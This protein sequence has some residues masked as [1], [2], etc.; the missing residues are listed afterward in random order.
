MRIATTKNCSAAFMKTLTLVFVFV[1]ISLM[2]AGTLVKS[3]MANPWF[4]V[5]FGTFSPRTL[6]SVTSPANQS[7]FKVNI[8]SLTF[9]I[10]MSEWYQYDELPFISSKYLS[11][12][13]IEYYLDGELAG[14]IA[15]HL[16]KEAYSLSVPLNGVSNG[17]HSV[18]VKATTTGVNWQ[19]TQDSDGGISV[20]WYTSP[21]L[22]SSGVV[23][24]TVDGKSPTFTVQSPQ[25]KTYYEASIP[26]TFRISEQ[27]SRVAYSL[28]GSNEITIS[29]SALARIPHAPA[30]RGNLNLTGLS[31]GS[32]N[33]ILYA[34]D[35]MGNTGISETIQFTIAQETEGKQ[36]LSVALVA[37][38]LVSAA[39]IGVFT[40]LFYFVKV[41]K[42][43]HEP[44]LV[45]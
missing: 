36:T 15:G 41:K 24:F 7:T 39:T 40:L 22:D 6:I 28:D 31:G 12:S 38:A 30:W 13:P 10:D 5:P 16:S 19:K 43:S 27:A 26:L 17:L 29:E 25:N 42:H 44:Q 33:L 2:L 45:F 4:H 21:I 37:V 8:F 35:T 18:E 23:Y 9:T 32:H 3:G 20:H 11:L 14:E 1:L 34:T